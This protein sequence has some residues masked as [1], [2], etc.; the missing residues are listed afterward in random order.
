MI[1]TSF[2]EDLLEFVLTT[3]YSYYLKSSHDLHKYL[4]DWLSRLEFKCL[5]L[6]NTGLKSQFDFP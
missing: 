1:I 3:E 2:G 4:T 5:C 6:V